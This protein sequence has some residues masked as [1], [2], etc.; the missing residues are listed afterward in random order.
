MQY[1]IFYLILI[2]HCYLIVK[3]EETRAKNF[4][5]SV[6]APYF[7][8]TLCGT[9]FLWKFIYSIYFLRNTL[10]VVKTAVSSF[11]ESSRQQENA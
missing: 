1:F 8:S 10:Q 9:T 4:S 11:Y 6:A 7:F 3:A 5:L 2:E